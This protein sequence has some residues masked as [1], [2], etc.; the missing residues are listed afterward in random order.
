MIGGEALVVSAD[1]KPGEKIVQCGHCKRVLPIPASMVDKRFGR[2]GKSPARR[3]YERHCLRAH[4]TF[5]LIRVARR[6]LG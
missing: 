2:P 5:V 6:L 1:M 3:V 4:P